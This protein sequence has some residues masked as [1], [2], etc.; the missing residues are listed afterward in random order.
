MVEE[1]DSVLFQDL[2]IFTQ[3][4]KYKL[5]ELRK[6]SRA[7]ATMEMFTFLLAKPESDVDKFLEEIKL[8][9]KFIWNHICSEG[10][11]CF[12]FYDTRFL[13]LRL[14]FCLWYDGK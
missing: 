14:A 13:Q 12:R 5:C 8:K 3:E 2:D 7:K 9:K 6:V 4:E 1:I 11:G 10:M